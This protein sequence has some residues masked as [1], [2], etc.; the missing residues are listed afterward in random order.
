MGASDDP[1]T[2]P[3]DT[4]L[5]FY[6]TSEAV[7]LGQS[8]GAFGMFATDDIYVAIPVE[9]TGGVGFVKL[10]ILSP[11]GGIYQTSWRAFS[12]ASTAPTEVMHPDF[13][14]TLHVQRAQ[15]RV[16]VVPVPVAGTQ[17]TRYGMTGVFQA[18]ATMRGA[19]AHAFGSFEVVQ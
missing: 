17:I 19:E 5:A 3:L 6:P 9:Q 15:N 12:S 18:R 2:P 16:L 14:E 7:A 4:G 10:D 13:G 1:G 11:D 8:Q